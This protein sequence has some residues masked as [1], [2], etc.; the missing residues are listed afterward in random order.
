MRI[1]PVVLP[2]LL[3]GDTLCWMSC[4]LCSE[5]L[6]MRCFCALNL[7]LMRLQALLKGAD[8]YGD[9]SA[10]KGLVEGKGEHSS[11]QH[12][13]DCMQPLWCTLR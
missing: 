1:M 10:V 4:A 9:P 8:V 12:R 6:L 7:M 11:S 2:V 3:H 13:N 5:T